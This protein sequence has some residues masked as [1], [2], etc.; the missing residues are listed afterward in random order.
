MV[1]VE[2]FVVFC[3]KSFQISNDLK[4]GS[5]VLKMAGLNG[6]F[7]SD[8]DGGADFEGFNHFDVILAGRNAQR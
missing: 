1:A 6:L 3:S 4:L 5:N 2:V 8:S 7:D